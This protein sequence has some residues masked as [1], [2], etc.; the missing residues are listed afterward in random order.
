MKTSSWQTYTGPGRIG[1]SRGTPRRSPAG[2]KLYRPLAPGPWFNSVSHEEYEHRFFEQLAQLDARKV[3]DEL[4]K[5][6]GG[7]EPVLLC[8]EKPP[9]T[10]ENWCHRRLVAAWLELELD[11]SVPEMG[12]EEGYNRLCSGHGYP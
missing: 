2:Y 12:A 11:V 9:L 4:H 7:A 1:I 5:L 3:W 10:K 6:T 8:F